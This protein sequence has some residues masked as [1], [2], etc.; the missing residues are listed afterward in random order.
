MGGI[1]NLYISLDVKIFIFENDTKYPK[2]WDFRKE[3][4]GKN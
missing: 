4:T 3:P 2:I 1:K